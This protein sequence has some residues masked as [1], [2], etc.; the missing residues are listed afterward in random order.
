MPMSRD[1]VDKL[2]KDP[3]HDLIVKNT[4]SHFKKKNY[5]TFKEKKLGRFNADL[6]AIRDENLVIAIEAKT[7]KSEIRKGVGQA[8]SYMDWVHEVYLAVPSE[9]AELATE[10]L[11]NTSIGII[12]V[13]NKKVS[14]IKESKRVE[15]EPTKLIKLLNTTTGFCWICGR[16]FNV[17]PPTQKGEAGTYI[18]HKDIEPKLFK[19]LENSLGKKIKTK[20]SWIKICTVCSRI[21]GDAIHEFLKRVFEEKEL[22]NFDFEEYQL[23]EIKNYLKK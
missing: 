16:T 21:L 6:I 8:Y 23:K 1:E 15:P 19:A 5:A 14:I 4:N 11:R 22:P 20:G 10:L 13:I 17:V 9:S 18:A 3:Q 2:P 12:T 7:N